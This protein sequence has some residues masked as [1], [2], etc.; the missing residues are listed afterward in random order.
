MSAFF[1][2]LAD[3][4]NPGS[5]SGRLRRRRFER[6]QALLS[7]S[8]N[9]PCRILDIGGDEHYWRVMLPDLRLP[10]EITLLNL[11]SYA[12]FPDA[13]I[14]SLVGD[15]RDLS[16][17]PDGMFDLV[18]SNSLIEHLGGLEDQRR[19]AHEVRRLGRAYF[20][21]TPNRRFPI[22]PHF[23]L[24]FFQY[25]PLPLKTQV[26]RRFRPGW[27]RQRRVEAAV[28]DARL[29]RLLTYREMAALFPDGKIWQER[30]L[31]LSKSLI[32]YRPFAS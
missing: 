6:F 7:G 14:T 21:Q 26:A 24:P 20:I 29:I 12:H 31:G 32:A 30:F 15:A 5:V 8:P 23:L 27:Y 9:R 28:E 3:N 17:L 22:E 25:L 19:M 4:R 10:V 11:N 16:H 13:R 18:Y 1:R 2:Q